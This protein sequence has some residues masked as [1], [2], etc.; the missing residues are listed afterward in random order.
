MYYACMYNVW[1]CFLLCFRISCF[2]IR[3]TP[4]SPHTDPLSGYSSHMRHSGTHPIYSAR[5]TS[6]PIFPVI[7]PVFYWN[8]LI[9][10]NW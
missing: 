2:C 8:F 5:F 4:P 10:V 3:P 6:T 7:Q 9:S 1:H